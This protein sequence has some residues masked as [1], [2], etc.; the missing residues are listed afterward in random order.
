MMATMSD[1][2]FLAEADA[3]RL[4]V[5][6]TPGETVQEMIMNYMKTPRSATDK[7]DELIKI[8]SPS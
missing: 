8:D 2:E 3:Q 5:I 1:P 7:I 4:E 6:A